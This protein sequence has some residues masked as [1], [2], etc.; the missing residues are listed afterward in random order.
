MNRPTLTLLTD[1]GLAEPYVGQVKGVILS[2]LP[3]AAIV[4]LTHEVPAHEIRVGAILLADSV[5]HFPARTVHIAVVDPGVGSARR[6]IAAAAGEHF[7]V[8]PDNG[9]LSPAIEMLDPSPRV[10]VIESSECMAREVSR[11]FHGR[12]IFAPCAAH[13]AAGNPIESVGP[14]AGDV[15]RLELP[16]PKV[17]GATIEGEV[18]YTDRFGNAITNIR[19]EHLGMKRRDEVRVGGATVPMVRTYADVPEGKPCAFI[20]SSGRIEIA[21]NAG[22][23]ADVLGATPG[24]S[25]CIEGR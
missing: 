17:A 5:R 11:T 20:G 3:G 4:D 6:P 18:L 24:T 15:V 14:P 10:H 12:D 19:A 21:V 9:L 1:F 13:L 25:V 22:R 23:A 2:R 8:G 7:F 16:E